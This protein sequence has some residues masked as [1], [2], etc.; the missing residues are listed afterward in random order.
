VIIAAGILA[1]SVTFALFWI[2]EYV[3]KATI[4]EATERDRLRVM[5]PSKLRRIIRQEDGK[6][7]MYVD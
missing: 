2:T 6:A 3:W 7:L 4:K 5:G 1:G